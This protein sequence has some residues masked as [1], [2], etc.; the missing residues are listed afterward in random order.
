MNGYGGQGMAQQITPEQYAQALQAYDVMQRRQ[1]HQQTMARSGNPFAML[2]AALGGAL[3]GKFGKYKDTNMA[4]VEQQLLAF[5]EQKQ[6]E[7]AQIA[8]AKQRKEAEA[9]RAQQLEDDARKHNYAI[10]LEKTKANT[11]YQNSLN[12]QKDR[13]QFESM[14][15]K[16]QREYEAANQK[17]DYKS[18]IDLRKEFQ[19]LKPVKD[20]DEVNASYQKVVKSAENPSAASDI[21]LITGFMKMNDPGSTVREG[22][23]ATAANAGGVDAKIR[24]TYNN[25]LNGQRLTPEQRNDF[26]NASG[27]LYGSHAEQYQRIREQYATVAQNMNLDPDKVFINRQVADWQQKPQQE[28]EFKDGTVIEN[29]KGERMVMRNGQWVRQ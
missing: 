11:G 1:E 23:F 6:A 20:F 5:Q 15:S 21:A 17:P 26:V 28:S 25:L 29:D 10:D 12:L 16:A 22:E 27:Q 9:K 3:A 18:S 24:S 7:L 8:E 19:S 13:Q 2:G 14:Q 4:D